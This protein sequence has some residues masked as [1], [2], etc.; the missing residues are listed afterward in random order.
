VD[1]ANLAEFLADGYNV[2]TTG[3]TE[4]GKAFLADNLGARGTASRK[5]TRDDQRTDPTPRYAQAD[6]GVFGVLNL[7]LGCGA[8]PGSV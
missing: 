4:I 6:A 1:R 3:Y 2:L 8:A 5:R 7:W